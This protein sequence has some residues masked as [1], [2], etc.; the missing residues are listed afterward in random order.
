MEEQINQIKNDYLDNIGQAH[1]LQQLD[2]IFLDLF[3]KNGK[4]T[5]FPREFSKLSKDELK[6]VGPLFNQVKKELEQAIGNRRQEIR[7]E[8]YRKLNE[9][10]FDINAKVQNKKRKG[11]LHPLTQFEKKIADL[12]AKLGFQQYDAPHIDTDYNTYE[13][14]N[15]PKDSPARD[16]QDTFYISVPGNA[17]S[18][19]ID[20]KAPNPEDKLVLRGHT[21]NSEVRFMKEYK[22]PI[23]MMLIGRCFR[24]ENLDARH[25]H[26]FDQFEIVYIDRGVNMGNLQFL[27]EYFLK[28]VFGSEIKARLRTKYYPQVEP[29][30]GMDG[31]CIFCKGEGCKVCGNVGW[32]ELGGAG[33]IHPV[34]LKNGGIDPNIYSGL[35][36][37][38][39]PLRMAMLIYGIE[40]VR[41]FLSG[42]LRFLEKF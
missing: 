42:D 31:L 36:W 4:L 7:E 8:G 5:L 3:G 32:L 10:T 29:G 14:L 17:S 38:I 22:P 21:S 19:Y 12:F 1:T 16:L 27:S 6:K 2:Q 39:S 24:Y 23:R 11:H 35:A 26:T 13:V 25:E 28:A 40:D 15:I 41:L 33:M 30:A 18:A 37:G 20:V 34:A 9:E